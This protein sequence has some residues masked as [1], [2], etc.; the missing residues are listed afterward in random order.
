[1]QN[2]FQHVLQ[3]S[4]LEEKDIRAFQAGTH[5]EIYEKLGSHLMQLDDESGVYFAVWAPNAKEVAV[6]GDFNEWN[7]EGYHLYPRWDHSGIWEGF[8]PRLEKGTL[9]KYWIL[10]NNGKRGMK[11]DPYARRW[12]HPPNTASIVWDF[13]YKW[14]DDKWLLQRKKL[15]NKPKPYSCYEVHLESWQ[16]K[17]DGSSLNYHELADE[18]VPYVQRMGFTHI[19]LMPIMEYPYSPSWGYQI[20]GYYAASSRF[21]NPEGLMHPMASRNS[22]VPICMS[23]KIRAKDFIQIGNLP[24]STMVAMKYKVF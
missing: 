20:T 3:A 16:R 11:G 4:R 13:D 24:S 22:M 18:L 7:P 8:I 15:S 17:Q 2:K 6:V 1:M 19:E 12:Q 5:I 9:Y 10:S 23:T 14:K 21:G